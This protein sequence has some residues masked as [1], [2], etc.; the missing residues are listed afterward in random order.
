MRRVK[1]APKRRI[2][3]SLPEDAPP[4][5]L[6]RVQGMTPTGSEQGANLPKK[7]ALLAAGGAESG[8]LDAE[9]AQILLAWP[10]LPKAVR[11]GIL[12]MVRAAKTT[13]QGLGGQ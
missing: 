8:A 11:A 2:L 13:Q 9:G 12:A 4:R 7:T 10:A 6:S 3:R 1:P 5:S